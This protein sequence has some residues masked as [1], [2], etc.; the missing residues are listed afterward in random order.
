MLYSKQS[1]SENLEPSGRD[2]W[3][4]YANNDILTTLG[5][6]QEGKG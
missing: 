6:F 1:A 2:A 3:D 5:L 4:N